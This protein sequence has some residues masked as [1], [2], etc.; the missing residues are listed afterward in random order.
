MPLVG[1]GRSMSEAILVMTE[2]R[3]GCVG[4]VDAAGA[5]LGIVTDGDLR[6]HMAPDLLAKP[7][8]AIMTAGPKTIRR[9][10]LAAEAVGFMSQ[11]Q[12]TTLWV[13]EAGLPVGI[14]HIHD[15]LRAGVA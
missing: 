9:N 13:I 4:V 8:S 5:L 15:C 6:R 3:L 12:I 1:P 2:K 14:L 10:A 11:R 7:V